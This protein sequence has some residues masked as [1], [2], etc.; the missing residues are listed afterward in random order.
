MGAS[1]EVYDLAG[2]EYGNKAR[3]GQ[4]IS[5]SLLFTWIMRKFRKVNVSASTFLHCYVICTMSFT[6]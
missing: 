3:I 6:Q 2:R 4:A 5:Y 1:G